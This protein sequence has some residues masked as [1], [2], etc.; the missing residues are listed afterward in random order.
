MRFQRTLAASSKEIEITPGTQQMV[1][2]AYG[3]TPGLA[4]HN[5]NRGDKMVDF[6]TLGAS[7]AAGPVLWLHFILMAS[8]G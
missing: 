2:W 1:I 4:D 5:A 3:T 8:W 7:T 6:A